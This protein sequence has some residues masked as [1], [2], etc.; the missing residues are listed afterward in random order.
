MGPQSSNEQ[1]ADLV[2]EV[3]QVL[4]QGG[5]VLLPTDTVFG[6]AAKPSIPA[7]VQ[8]IFEIKARPAHKNLPLLIHSVQEIEK[9]GA[10][11]NS[12]AAKLL[13]SEFCPGPL[14]LAVELRAQDV[15]EWLAGRDELAFRLPKDD[16]LL[17]LLART[18]PLVATSANMHGLQ[19][20]PTASAALAQLALQP[21]YVVEGAECSVTPSTLVN[22]R[23]AVPI[24][25]RVGEVPEHEIQRILGAK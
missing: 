25:E 11:V 16:F 22:C 17:A 13:A 4:E 19:T 5:V 14:T 8:R 18:G 15:P 10:I 24:I 20:L 1:A 2:G 21:D 3:A 7:A 23:A 6:L 9:L 12:T